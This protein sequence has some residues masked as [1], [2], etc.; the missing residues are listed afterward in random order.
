M[1]GSSFEWFR[2]S[3]LLGIPENENAGNWPKRFNAS[4]L[5]KLQESEDEKEFEAFRQWINTPQTNKPQGEKVTRRISE[6]DIGARLQVVL[7]PQYEG[8]APFVGEGITDHWKTVTPEFV[9]RANRCLYPNS[10]MNADR[11]VDTLYTAMDLIVMLQL[12]NK[13]PSQFVKAWFD[14]MGVALHEHSKPW[15]LPDDRDKPPATENWQ[16]AARYFYR[17]FKTANSESLKKDIVPLVRDKL[18]ERQ[19][20]K[21]GGQKLPSEAAIDKVL[22]NIEL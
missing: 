11:V 17:Q 22:Q 7:R 13:E 16:I 18:Q 12:T 5:A 15:L 4:D 3:Q 6:R 2:A 20:Y 19:L 14:S 21:R 9:E 1:K 10:P 8:I